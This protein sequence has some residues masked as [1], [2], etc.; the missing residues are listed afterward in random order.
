MYTLVGGVL[1]LADGMSCMD[2]RQ[3]FSSGALPSSES[4]GTG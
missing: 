4:E 2:K 1:G 3:E